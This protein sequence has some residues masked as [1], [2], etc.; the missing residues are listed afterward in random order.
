MRNLFGETVK[1]T[2]LETCKYCGYKAKKIDNRHYKH[3]FK[4]PYFKSK[5]KP[6]TQNRLGMINNILLN[7]SLYLPKDLTTITLHN[8]KVIHMAFIDGNFV[9]LA[10][11]FARAFNETP[12][13]MAQRWRNEK[14][15][16]MIS[17]PKKITYKR[18]STEFG[19]LMKKAMVGRASTYI[20][21]REDDMIYL[22]SIPSHKQAKLA[23]KELIV[24]NLK[25]KYWITDLIYKLGKCNNRE[26]KFL[27]AW[28][29]LGYA[30][31]EI[32]PQQWYRLPNKINRRIDF[33]LHEGELLVEIDNVE[34]HNRYKD[35][36]TD[37]AFFEKNKL[38][39]RF[40]NSEIDENPLKV[41]RQTINIAKKYKIFIKQEVLPTFIKG[42][43]K[44]KV[45]AAKLI[46]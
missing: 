45:E 30:L 43:V 34:A 19:R 44:N 39:I 29:R 11:E 40:E 6:T 28:L 14:K 3:C 32:I 4:S 16:G 12:K 13:T 9:C 18:L 20:L 33:K 31:E 10:P 2:N 27:C 24:F 42:F 8:D 1:I 21:L 15:K 7:T 41:V 25:A 46:N 35:I 37:R 36:T 22:A 38:I 26:F 17:Y 23:L 5:L